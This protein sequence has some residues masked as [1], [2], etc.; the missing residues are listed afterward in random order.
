[1]EERQKKLYESLDTICEKLDNA[2][3]QELIEVIR[4]VRLHSYTMLPV[5]NRW[6][7]NKR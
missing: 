6:L 7:E 4:T 3:Q 5:L 2:G 1:M